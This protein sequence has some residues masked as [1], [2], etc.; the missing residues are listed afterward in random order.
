MPREFDPL[1]LPEEESP[2]AV[3]L[4]GD[5]PARS[6]VVQ[7]LRQ[8]NARSK[9]A[10]VGAVNQNLDPDREAS[11]QR[12]S[13]KLGMPP[14]A[15]RPLLDEYEK[16][17]DRPQVDL[18][19]LHDT[20]P[21]LSRFV[22]KRPGVADDDISELRGLTWAIKG[23]GFAME[24]GKAQVE[25]GKIG[26]KQLEG[27]ATPEDKARA[28][29]LERGIM[30]RYLGDETWLQSAF[31]EAGKMLPQLT[32]ATEY[33]SVGAAGAFLAGQAGPQV[34]IPE[35]LFSMPGAALAGTFLWTYQQEAGGAFR[36]FDAIENPRTGEGLDPEDVRI[37]ALSTGIVNGIVEGLSIGRFLKHVPGAKQFLGGLMER[38]LRQHITSRTLTRAAG[39]YGLTTATTMA[40]EG[41][42][43]FTQEMSTIGAAAILKQVDAGEW[44]PENWKENF[45][46]A[47]EAF[48]K[49]AGA[50]MFL[51][52][53]TGMPS[54]YN[55]VRTSRKATNHRAR[56]EMQ[57]GHVRKS[58]LF[59][60]SPELGEEEVKDQLDSAPQAAKNIYVPVEKWNEA[61][62]KADLD[63]RIIA[64]QIIGEGAH[65]QATADGGQG[66]L[67]IPVERYLSKVSLTELHEVIAD[68]TRS[69]PEG[70]SINETR[71]LQKDV[72][73]DLKKAIQFAEEAEPD[74]LPEM[75]EAEKTIFE[76]EEAAI[77]GSTGNAE[78]ARVQALIHAK[79]VTTRARKAGIDP[80]EHYEAYEVRYHQQDARAAEANVRD[81]LQ[82]QAGYS[83]RAVRDM[84][85]IADPSQD[86]IATQEVADGLEKSEQ[87]AIDQAA[88]EM[89]P[90]VPKNVKRLVP[91][92]DAEGSTAANLALA[93]AVAKKVGVSVAD[94]LVQ[95]EE[96]AGEEAAPDDRRAAGRKSDDR[97]KNLRAR[98][99]FAR[100]I[101]EKRITEEEQVDALREAIAGRDVGE[102]VA[103]A[104]ERFD[105]R[106]SEKA[107]PDI[108]KDDDV[109][110][111]AGT[112]KTGRT[113]AE[114]QKQLPRAKYLTYVQE[115]QEPKQG[116]V[117]T[118]QPSAFDI[119]RPDKLPRRE[120]ASIELESGLSDPEG[121]E[122]FAYR[123][124]DGSGFEI[125][126]ALFR[127]SGSKLHMSS[128]GDTLRFRPG[129]LGV[130]GV[131]KLI[132]RIKK[133]FPEVESIT[134]NRVSGVRE[135]QHAINE[136]LAQEGRISIEE[137]R[138][139]IRDAPDPIVKLNQAFQGEGGSKKPHRGEIRFTKGGRKFDVS[140]FETSDPTTVI[141]EIAHFHLEVL[142][143]LAGEVG[144][145]EAIKDDFAT[146]MGFLGLQIDDEITLEHHERF[147]NGFEQYLREGIAPT[148]EL[149]GLFA[150][151]KGWMLEV[152]G[153]VREL[154][155]LT[156][157]MRSVFD[158]ML[159]SDQQIK[160]AQEELNLSPIPALSKEM[161]EDDRGEYV[162]AQEAAAREGEDAL[163]VTLLG[164]EQRADQ[165]LQDR[166]A[167]I[168]REVEE[169]FSKSPKMR[170][171]HFLQKG[172]MIGSGDL[173]PDLMT[174]RGEG[175]QNF[176]VRLSRKIILERYGLDTLQSLPKDEYV[177]TSKED[178]A[179]DPDELAPFFGFMNGTELIEALR[180]APRYNDALAQAVQRKIDAR[181][182][183][184]MKDPPRMARE[185]LAA[186]QGDKRIEQLIIEVRWIQ[187]K[188]N[189]RRTARRSRPF[190]REELKAAAKRTIDT[191]TLARLKPWVYQRNAQKHGRLAFEAAEKGDLGKAFDQKSLQL[192]NMILY[193]E[194]RD[195]QKQ[196]EG[197]LAF[198]RRMQ[199]APA[200]ATLGKAGANYL[201]TVNSLLQKFELRATTGPQLQ[202]RVNLRKFIEEQ[203]EQG[204]EAII[205]PDLEDKAKT[206]YREL[207]VADMR[208]LIVGIKNVYGLAKLKTKMQT[209]QGDRDFND[210][211]NALVQ[212]AE[213]NVFS[214]GK[215]PADAGKR[216]RQ[217]GGLSGITKQFA[218]IDASLLKMEAVITDMLDG[219]N[220][221]GVWTQT[222]WQ[223]IV[224]AQK[225]SQDMMQDIVMRISKA[226]D[227]LP[228]KQRKAILTRDIF[229][230]SA[231]ETITMEAA[232][233]TA[234][235]WGNESNRSKL[236]RGG[237]GLKV[238]NTDVLEEILGNLSRADWILVQDM[239]TIIGSMWP[240]I[241]AMERRLTGVPPP[242]VDP[243]PF[244]R[245][246]EDGKPLNL[247]G[248]YMPLVYS[249]QA[250]MPVSNEAN[251]NQVL[252]DHRHT[253]AMTAHGH[254]NARQEGFKA[255]LDT[256]LDAIPRHLSQVV[257]DL[258]HR[259]AV[260]QAHKIINN[261][262]VKQVLRDRLGPAKWD[263][264]NEWVKRVARDQTTSG[265]DRALMKIMRT[266]RSNFTVWVMGYKATTSLQN[267]ANIFNV[268]QPRK[269]VKPGSFAKAAK[270]FITDY[271]AT[272]AFVNDSSAEMKHRFANLDRDIR[273]AMEEGLL[274][275]KNK[276]A[277]QKGMFIARKNAFRPIIW[278]DAMIAYPTWLAAF[279][280]Q[281]D[282]GKS[283][284][285]A[286]N[287]ADRVIRSTLSSGANKDIASVQSGDEGAKWM[288]MFFTFFNGLYSRHRILARDVRESGRNKALLRNLPSH[289]VELMM[290]SLMPILLAEVLSGRAPDFDD[291]AEDWWE[292]AKFESLFFP[293]AMIPGVREI[294]NGVEG[295]L[296][297][298]RRSV[299][300]GPLGSVAEQ[301]IRAWAKIVGGKADFD[302]QV[303]SALDITGSLTGIPP[304][305][306]VITLQYWYDL[307]TGDE[308]VDS[309][310][311]FLRDTAFR[312]KP[313]K[314][315]TGL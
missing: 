248:G 223:P 136:R 163:R 45:E 181:F 126:Q 229:L 137:F 277:L 241:E 105:E 11:V 113:I 34:A 6:S 88:E 300:Y 144:A 87:G 168:E 244:V 63:P 207:T 77:L 131:R 1:A 170:L 112:R 38:K 70:R 122:L 210:T 175:K 247:A 156:K 104:H 79:M 103:D 183:D 43:E 217:Q 182:R 219:G 25:V 161:T 86:E 221:D 56:L 224:E 32:G 176:G 202:R 274:G 231:G 39:R 203:Q 139:R 259:E 267:F 271:T 310:G 180:D 197:G 299:S 92:P 157:E 159:A 195:A 142:S 134:G 33:A 167:D 213:E 209:S 218:S 98:K 292:W 172:R 62:E 119:K 16:E 107:L 188:L 90:R 236:V 295:A 186:V 196:A 304:A 297:G 152:Y 78:A 21:V 280:E 145:T 10:L 245:E 283:R 315:A 192:W 151:I 184:I 187:R 125:T 2:L 35:E 303:K 50:S 265:N 177:Y 133:D 102:A 135:Q 199:K 37:A 20:D 121:G 235:H 154:L 116:E 233:M 205:S 296:T 4:F 284:K 237:I 232:L 9:A 36:E 76:Q 5:D 311:D 288:T 58:K 82:T 24:Q 49:G 117:V 52:G 127:V 264:M 164:E 128:I 115:L 129:S 174:D 190:N 101:E 3:S 215:F 42:A 240:Q 314:K 19:L 91:V 246:F 206:H 8:S 171:V 132:A 61:L 55:D 287:H 228:T 279:R 230:K 193:R 93:E 258:T 53:A 44:E 158:R 40:V 71:Q 220:T 243:M 201:N 7:G 99:A 226:F 222:I 256:S 124:L 14:D 289:A 13:K 165:F 51:G 26:L 146:V 262:R 251:A 15:V 261:E 198:L 273:F 281:N 48:S 120:I 253:R 291:D 47:F 66:D 204:L 191:V 153:Q 57:T 312:R 276:N 68:D 179:I 282:A 60:R 147:A 84:T 67:V 208:T 27:T 106:T 94:I 234:L 293:A 268:L 85:L 111:I 143:Q 31:I 18:K 308:T 250:T 249:P 96:T 216:R 149:R 270:D 189:P 118:H 212:S 286:I 83:A 298:K 41:S 17:A 194:T 155:Q 72:E 302:E 81:G 30:S 305:Q 110:L 252:F 272:A 160:A 285:Q 173:A 169:E 178:R 275:L 301:Q 123:L 97:R 141:H 23:F 257:H 130:S 89:A 109:L 138:A 211:I 65:A 148:E 255:T 294:A 59:K 263:R 242:R 114:A 100:A 185:A 108:D 69:D 46:R 309:V 269:G 162:A 73:A 227:K 278:T 74:A 95:E 239:W 28:T 313:K 166:R 225:A 54:L 266:M 80:V 214:G 64:D 150:T 307:A 29:E 260:L 12:V 200:Q 22:T 75:T 290:I 254:I 238:W 306:L 140:M